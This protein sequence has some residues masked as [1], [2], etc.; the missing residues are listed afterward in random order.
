MAKLLTTICIAM[1]LSMTGVSAGWFDSSPSSPTSSSGLAMQH[2]TL[3]PVKDGMSAEQWLVSQKLIHDNELGG[4]RYVYLIGENGQVA[5]HFVISNKVTSSG[6]RLTPRTVAAYGGDG[7]GTSGMDITIGSRTYETNEVIE[8]DGTYGD[9]GQYYY[10]W[11]TSGNFVKVIPM[12]SF[13]M[14]E[15]DKQLTPTELTFTVTSE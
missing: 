2:T 7:Y 6:K 15:S 3:S 9:S 13:I 12:G 10:M 11:T 5:L 4:I 14:V 8:D 1:L